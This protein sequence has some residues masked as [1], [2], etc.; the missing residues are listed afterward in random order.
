M[1][2]SDYQV[3]DGCH[4]CDYGKTSFCGDE[5]SCEYR[6]VDGHTEWVQYAGICSNWRPRKVHAGGEGE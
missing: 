6:P 1:R 3:M 2:N 5:I 4:N